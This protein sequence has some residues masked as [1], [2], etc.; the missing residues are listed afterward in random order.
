MVLVFTF[1]ENALDAGVFA[2]QRVV[3]VLVVLY[4]FA[5]PW[6]YALELGE[7]VGNI[8]RL[9][10][11][12]LLAGAIPAALARKGLR[13]PGRMQW[14]TLALFLYFAASCLWSIEPAETLIKMRAYFQVMAIVWVAWEFVETADDLRNLLRALVAGC[15]VLAVLTLVNFSS[16][17]SAV[18]AEQ[19]RFVAE[20]QD[21]NDVARFLDLG[22]P[23]AA[24]L[25]ATD[26]R[27]VVRWL[28]LGYLPVGLLAVVLTASRG[29]FVASLAALVCV[30][31]LIARWRPVA[32]LSATVGLTVAASVSL[33]FVPVDTYA[34]L[35]TIPE[36][37]ASADFNN[38][39]NIWESGWAAFRHAPWLGYGAGNFSL[40]AG[41]SAED[42]AHN[43]L[44]AVLV[45]GGL[46]GGALLAG[47]V[48]SAAQKALRAEGL[49]RIAMVSSLVVWGIT[50]SVGSV[51]ENRM[52]WLVFAWIGVAG[53]IAG[54]E[55]ERTGLGTGLETGLESGLG[56]L[57]DG[58]AGWRA[59]GLTRQSGRGRLAGALRSG[60]V[61]TG[62]VHT[63][64][65][66]V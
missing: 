39:F 1:P 52:T 48:V 57:V 9:V 47:V 6:E 31:F 29:G 17:S 7:P 24:L 11:L 54:I 55:R 13:T 46:V 62:S 18:V 53:R 4:A 22:F 37:F 25:F 60:S 58:W 65:A 33:F 44:M 27:R 5:V 63:G 35:A 32:A 59:G 56:T 64:S 20:G 15:W 12:V 38:R 61:R 3:A 50:S 34:R 10:G 30:L 51:E 42:T 45:M 36:Q 66:G 14:L 2:M 8:A 28:A 21:P 41:L 16:V 43:T 26:G 40:A 23:V 49:L 19:T